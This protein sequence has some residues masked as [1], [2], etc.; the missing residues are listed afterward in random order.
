MKSNAFRPK[1][2]LTVLTLL[3]APTVTYAMS[4]MEMPAS[5]NAKAATSLSK[6]MGEPINSSESE[7]EM[8]YSADGKTVIFVSG[9]KGSIRHL[10][11][12][13]TS[14]FGWPTM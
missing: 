14:T 1:D 10:A 11:F 2:C 6:S 4:G 13:T 9:R 12:P 5:G 7:I 8:T 3:L